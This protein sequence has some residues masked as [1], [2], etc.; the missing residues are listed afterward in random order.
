VRNVLLL[1]ALVASAPSA[2]S[3]QPVRRTG[4]AELGAVAPGAAVVVLLDDGR[5]LERHI[6]GTTA[7]TLITVDLS[8]IALRDR[9]EQVL[10]LIHDRPQQYFTRAFVEANGVLIP[11]VQRFDRTS[12]V[13]VARPRPLVFSPPAPLAW[14]LSNSVY[15]GPCPN[16]DAAQTALGPTPL[17]SPLPRRAASDSLVG[18][19]LYA[20]PAATAINPLDA[21][22]WQQLKPLLPAS[23]RGVGR[24]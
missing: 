3:E 8:R 2:A 6:V 18:E 24:Q 4:W 1:A 9:R 19:M 5:R 20:A 17:P 22:S 13:A 11:I 12:I 16:C 23:L 15:S 10:A 7:D 21:V 14:M